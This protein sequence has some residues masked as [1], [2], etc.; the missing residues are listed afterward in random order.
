MSTAEVAQGLVDAEGRLVEADDALV[1]LN[2][3][4][5]GRLGSP[6]AIPQLATLARLSRRLGVPISRGVVVADRETDIELY[7]R[8]RPERDGVRLAVAGW[9]ERRPWRAQ[10]EAVRAELLAADAHWRWECDSSLRFDFVS[11]A[12]GIRHGFDAV[13]LLGRPVAELFCFETDS[14]PFGERRSFESR[15]ATLRRSGQPILVSAVARYDA[16][17]T[18]AGYDGSVR[19]VE[20]PAQ[21]AKASAIGMADQLGRALRS[22]LGMIVANAD[23]IQAGADGPVGEGYAGYAADIANAGR[24]LMALLDDLTDL[25]A[26][27]RPDFTPEMERIDLADLVR[28]AAGL[29]SVR[30]ANA[31]VTIARPGSD[32]VAF[33][34]GDFRRVLQVLV[35]LIGNAVRYSPLG[36]IVTVAVARNGRVMVADTGKGIAA[37][38]QARI[39]DK[40]ARV[41]PSE[42]GGSG[43]GLYIAR[44][45]ARAMGGDVTVESA[46]GE[47]ARFTLT[48]R[49]DPPSDQD[50]RE[51]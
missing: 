28:R 4:A 44:R 41:D 22:S 39:F 51:P 24:H 18:L 25:E 12:A 27:E 36:G 3:R 11:I 35:N 6:L 16:E 50:Q 14:D 43:L 42:P 34:R 17:G 5:G 45:L 10:S 23:S 21:D 13:G 2:L 33:A 31:G 9:R 48:L 19:A 7:V 40:F 32:E 46:P 37:E 20:P 8:V 47:G 1:G 49:P 30:A 26:V 38:D 15:P 29:L